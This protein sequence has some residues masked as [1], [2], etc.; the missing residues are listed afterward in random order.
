M[1]TRWLVRMPVGIPTTYV[2]D[3]G[4]M[5]IPTSLRDSTALK[6]ASEEI[7][8][9]A[10]SPGSVELE[11]NVHLEPNVLVVAAGGARPRGFMQQ[12]LGRYPPLVARR[13]SVR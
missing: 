8:P 10:F 1:A 11:P 9:A 13:R 4:K 2:Q 3:F 7:G 12:P 6:T 5:F